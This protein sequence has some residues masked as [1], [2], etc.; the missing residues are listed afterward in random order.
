MIIT[1]GNNKKMHNKAL[2]WTGGHGGFSEV[3]LTGKFTGQPKL[4]G[5]ISAG[6]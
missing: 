3:N 6:P 2:Q 1:A 4:S 5:I